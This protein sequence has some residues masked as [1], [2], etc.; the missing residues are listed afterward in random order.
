V[1]KTK[2]KAGQNVNRMKGVGGDEG[3]NNRQMDMNEERLFRDKILSFISTLS[4]LIVSVFAGPL[5]V[6]GRGISF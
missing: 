2:E 4:N 3:K 1:I 6:Q 5:V